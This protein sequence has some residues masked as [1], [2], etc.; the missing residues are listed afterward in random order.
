MSLKNPKSIV[1]LGY[2]LQHSLSPLLHNFAFNQLG[3]DFTYNAY[4]IQPER[5]NDL[6]KDFLRILPIYGG[7]VTVPFKELVFNYLDNISDIASEVGAVNT[8][9][10]KDGILYGDNTDV[11]G[12]IES[13]SDV[14]ESFTKKTVMMLGTGGSAKAV[15]TALEKLNV[16]KIIVL[17]RKLEKSKLFVDNKSQLYPHIEMINLDYQNLLTYNQIKEV[18]V[19]I[20][21]T[22]LGMYENIS[23]LQEDIINKFNENTFIY[24]LIYNPEKTKFLNLAENRGLKIRNGKMMLVY[25]AA[26]AF[27]LWT[28]FDF[29]IENALNLI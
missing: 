12:F 1:L 15:I 21:T 11:Y 19:V 10:K 26:K 23:P 7:N 25:Q 28:G 4:P 17:S 6:G 13:V 2:P 22:P 3:L 29:P 18:S 5:L 9:Y 8:F 20:N 16:Q 27:K 24:D 14:K